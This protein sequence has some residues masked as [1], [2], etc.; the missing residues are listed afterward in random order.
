MMTGVLSA[1]Q[2]ERLEYI[3]QSLYRLVDE[4]NLIAGSQCSGL[5][6]GGVGGDWAVSS[7]EPKSPRKARVSRRP[8]RGVQVQG[9][10][11]VSPGSEVSPVLVNGHAGHNGS[12]DG[13]QDGIDGKDGKSPRQALAELGR[14]A[15]V[16]EIS[17]YIGVPT[18]V[19]RNRISSLLVRGVV[20]PVPGSSPRMYELAGGQ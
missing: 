13:G 14:P 2:R 11:S 10:F 15:T 6:S 5:P 17:E 20:R 7:H 16:Q 3:K 4:L 8:V 18:R 12:R 9:G 19:A 1:G